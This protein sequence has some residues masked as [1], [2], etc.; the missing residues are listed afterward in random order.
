MDK[1]VTII[2]PVYNKQ[3][4]FLHDCIESI[5]RLNIDHH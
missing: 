5:N 4:L 2:V 3:E 1:L